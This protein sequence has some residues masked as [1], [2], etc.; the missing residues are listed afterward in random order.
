MSIFAR[1]AHDFGRAQKARKQ[2]AAKPLK[3]NGPANL[4]DFAP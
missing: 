1:P 3:N 2:S 4:L